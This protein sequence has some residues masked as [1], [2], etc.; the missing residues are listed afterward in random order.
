MLYFIIKI[1]KN[2]I[3][4]FLS[5]IKKNVL[6]HK[7]KVLI[8]NSKLKNMMIAETW[9]SRKS[10]EPLSQKAKAVVLMTAFDCSDSIGILLLEI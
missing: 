6:K 1:I 4:T 7:C 9:F 5:K 3:K 10:I 8:S 2:T